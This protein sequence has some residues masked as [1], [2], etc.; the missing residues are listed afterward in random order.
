MKDNR[1]KTLKSIYTTLFSQKFSPDGNELAVCSNFG[2]ISLFNLTSILSIESIDKLK[3]PFLKFK[4][5]DSCLYSL[6]ST[7]DYLISGA[8]NEIIGWK[9]KD[10]VKKNHSKAFTI[11]TSTD[12]YINNLVEINSLV[13]DEKIEPKLLYAACGNGEIMCID[14]ET[15]Q[16]IRKI[17]AHNDC[18]YQIVVKKNQ[19]FSASEDGEVK[20]WD[21]RSENG[22]SFTV[23]PYEN[24]ICSRPHYGRHINCI[25]IDD[26]NWMIA[27]GGPKLT[28]W[29]LRS[30]KPMNTIEPDQ[31][32]IP[33]TCVLYDNQILTGGN[34]NRLYNYSF[35]N[36]LKREIIT[37]PTCVYDI[38]INNA[39]KSNKVAPCAGTIVGSGSTIDLCLNFSYKSLSMKF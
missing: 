23:K 16:I 18:I 2:E 33:N 20:L 13:Y 21:L 31:S 10:L 14:L 36:K 38:S 12:N 8:V 7:S 5:S 9:W 37:T 34:R 39:V 6:E 3:L 26:D 28:I 1:D 4:A 32:Y 29:H 17:K 35:D 25:A 15:G 30:L 24:E 19:L 22:N 11:K 27:G